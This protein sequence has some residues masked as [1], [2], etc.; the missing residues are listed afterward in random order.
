MAVE[1]HDRQRLM[2]PSPV[3]TTPPVEEEDEWVMLLQFCPFVVC[4]FGSREKKQ[5]NLLESLDLYL[6]IY[7]FLIDIDLIWVSFWIFKLWVL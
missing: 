7:C 6:F 5:G 2:D 4:L 1:I 3:H